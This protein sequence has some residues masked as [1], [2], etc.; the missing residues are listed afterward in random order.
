MDYTEIIEC[1]DELKIM[2]LKY[3]STN[4]FDYD[5]YDMILDKFGLINNFEDETQMKLLNLFYNMND[6]IVNHNTII[7]SHKTIMINNLIINLAIDVQIKNI[8][9][10]PIPKTMIKNYE[11]IKMMIQK[12]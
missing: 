9:H 4:T 2:I 1:I 5:E 7:K 12:N 8:L 6:Y 3:N 11:L 10:E